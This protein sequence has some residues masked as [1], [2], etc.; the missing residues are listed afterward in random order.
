MAKKSQTSS[1]SSPTT[2]PKDPLILTLVLV[3]IL[4]I[5]HYALSPPWDLLRAQHFNTALGT[6]A[7]APCLLAAIGILFGGI[8]PTTGREIPKSLQPNHRAILLVMVPLIV[9]T[10]ISAFHQPLR[11]PPADWMERVIMRALTVGGAFGLLTLFWQGTAQMGLFK[12]ASPALRAL[13]ITALGTSIYVP[14]LFTTE[15]TVNAPVMVGAI[16][17]LLAVPAILHELGV[18]LW[19]LALISF[20]T[21]VAAVYAHPSPLLL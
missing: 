11:F 1:P 2:G 19:V 16:A 8:L 3:F 17:L 15:S 20:A 14:Y 12:K 7:T 6:W 10:L 18:K 9:I 21:A 5:A 13:G 4:L